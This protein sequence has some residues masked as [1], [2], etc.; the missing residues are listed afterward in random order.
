MLDSLS[1]ALYP[2]T[3]VVEGMVDIDDVLNPEV[4]SIIRMRQPGMVQQLDVPFLG[5][6]AFPMV[7]YLDDMKESRT[8]QTAAS[9]GLDPDVLQSTTRAA[10]TAT[11]RGA[12]QHLEMMARLFAE[13]G[14]KRLFKGLLR[15]IITH[16]D[17]ERV[18]R[19][20]NEWVP[21]DPRVWDSSMDCT[22][23]VGLGSGMTDERLAVLNQV[24]VRQTEA[25]EKLGPDNPLVGLGNIRNTLAKMLEISGYK[26]TD[27]FFKPLPIDWQ[28]PPPEPPP[29]TPEELLAQ[30]QMADIQARTAIDQQKLE[31]DVM[32]ARQL[33]ERES[34]RIAGDIAIREFQAEEK[35]DNEVDLEIL[36]KR[37]EDE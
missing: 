8:G 10:V 20:R 29:P 25:L 14:F 13:D 27:Q 18:V 6:E 12:E 7:A 16:Q 5:K 30:A 22:V 26:D 36:K 4:G 33:D 28:P 24:V 2:R 17:R 15:L 34:V 35:F 21:V 23:N 31:V 9:Q 3:G 32:K 11:I 1:F 37:L 19:L